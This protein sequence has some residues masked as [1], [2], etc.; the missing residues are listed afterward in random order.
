M[1]YFEAKL[2]RAPQTPYV[3]LRGL[4]SKGRGGIGKRKKGGGQ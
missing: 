4:L 2:H 1:S 3:D